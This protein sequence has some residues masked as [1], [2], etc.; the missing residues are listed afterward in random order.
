MTDFSNFIFDLGGGYTI[1]RNTTLSDAKKS[2]EKYLRQLTLGIDPST[3]EIDTEMFAKGIMIPYEGFADNIMFD[4]TFNFEGEK[5]KC[6]EIDK[7]A[8]DVFVKET[9]KIELQYDMDLINYEEC[10]RKH[11][12]SEIKKMSLLFP[13]KELTVNTESHVSGDFLRTDEY[14]KMSFDWGTSAFCFSYNKHNV[15]YYFSSICMF[16]KN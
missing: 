2:P 8:S 16:P 1:D 7:M 12:E 10:M 5:L 11:A 4:F 15:E 13:C 14:Y 9:E 3:K 6:V